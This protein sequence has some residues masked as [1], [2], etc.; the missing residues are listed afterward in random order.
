[1]KGKKKKK[2]YYYMRGWGFAAVVF[3]VI[4]IIFSYNIASMVTDARVIKAKEDTNEV[5][6]N[7]MECSDGPIID[8]GGPY[9]GTEG[10]YIPFK[11]CVIGGVPPYDWYI[12]WGD[13]TNQTEEKVEEPCLELAHKYAS[14]GIYLITIYVV[15]GNGKN[16]TAITY[17]TIEDPDDPNLIIIIETDYYW[18]ADQM[19]ILVIL[20]ITVS[21]YGD[22]E[23]VDYNITITISGPKNLEVSFAGDP[24]CA[25]CMRVYLKG[26][27]LKVGIYSANASLSSG[28][29]DGKIVIDYDD[30]TFFVLPE[31]LCRFMEGLPEWLRDFF[32]DFIF[33]FLLPFYARMYPY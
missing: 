32:E 14:A 26:Y 29:G 20:T 10:E 16:D 25:G 12:D 22:E 30:C 24:I 4:V 3:T 18:C 15:D 23:C 1:M 33:P 21:N 2:M 19:A 13:G 27:Y 9:K 6:P 8:P 11:F 28:S 31:K 17:V 5:S 7:I